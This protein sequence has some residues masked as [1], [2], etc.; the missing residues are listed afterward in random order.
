MPIMHQ[1][2][3]YGPVFSCVPDGFSRIAFVDRIRVSRL[4]LCFVS[5]DEDV[6]CSPTSIAYL[7]QLAC[8]AKD[9]W[10]V[11]PDLEDFSYSGG[12]A[13]MSFGWF[14]VNCRRICAAS[15]PAMHLHMT[16]DLKVSRKPI[17]EAVVFMPSQSFEHLI[18]ELKRKVIFSGCVVQ[19]TIVD[20]Y[21]PSDD[22]P[23]R[24]ELIL[25]I[26]YYGHS[27]FRWND[28]DRAY[29]RTVGDGID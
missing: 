25:L 11:K 2:I 26:L 12:D 3:L 21:A 6:S 22:C 1:L 28:L 14:A 7:D 15:S 20:T 27:S 23:L 18:D 9:M 16:R 10:P 17:Q 8:I 29:P 24:D 19:F 13:M 4:A 5:F